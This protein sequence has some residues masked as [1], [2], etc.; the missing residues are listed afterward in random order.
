MLT[1]HRLQS[2]N[3][4][5]DAILK[6]SSTPSIPPVSLDQ[7]Q[8][9]P[10][11]GERR[12]KLRPPPEESPAP[13]EGL[14]VAL[15]DPSQ[16]AIYNSLMNPGRSHPSAPPA[17]TAATLSAHISALAAKLEP[18]IDIFADGVHKVAQLR[19]TAERV[20]DK[21]LGSAAEGLEER[22]REVRVQAAS[23]R[24]VPGEGVADVRDVLNALAGVLNGD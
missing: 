18:A 20:A 7:P 3:A 13:A 17:S 19:G 15:L 9:A 24:G 8:P 11:D 5:L 6:E 10:P 1:F 16:L 4:E 23:E 12:P 21:I 2:E 22:S 14:D